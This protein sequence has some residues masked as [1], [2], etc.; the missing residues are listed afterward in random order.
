MTKQ[1]RKTK[2]VTL[3]ITSEEYR[4]LRLKQNETGQSLSEIIRNEYLIAATERYFAQHKPGR[5]GKHPPS[6]KGNAND[7]PVPTSVIHWATGPD[8]RATQISGEWMEH[9]GRSPVGD[10]GDLWASCVHVEDR[11]DLTRIFTE[12]MKSRV[13]YTFEYRLRRPDGGFNWVQAQA[14]PH[15]GTDG[16]FLGYIGTTTAITSADNGRMLMMA[17]YTAP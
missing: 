16:T 9:T 13:P 4:C 14:N 11:D 8:G 1:G 2:S 6:L 3:R 12:C 10:L 5:R 15:F 7:L 17:P